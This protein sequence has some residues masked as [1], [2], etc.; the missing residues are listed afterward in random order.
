MAYHYGELSEAD[1]FY[2]RIMPLVDNVLAQPN[3]AEEA[4]TILMFGVFWWTIAVDLNNTAPY[5]RAMEK[6]QLT[7]AE[8]DA[9]IA[10][11]VPHATLPGTQEY[12]S[13]CI[14]ASYILVGGSTGDASV[15][16]IVATLPTWDEH[17]EISKL[18]YA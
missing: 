6:L 1:H 12:Y 16:D 18:G 5:L 8:A 11:H 10:Q 7:W 14:K 4:Q 13:A 2:E 9:T 3:Q 17:I 15:D